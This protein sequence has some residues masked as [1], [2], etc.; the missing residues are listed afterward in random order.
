[1]R[2][3]LQNKIWNIFISNVFLKKIFDIIW[4]YLIWAALKK[5]K[6]V[7]QCYPPKATFWPF[8]YLA[9]RYG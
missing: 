5:Q 6:S 4:L 2:N 7:V 8:Y 3:D 1:M 9:G